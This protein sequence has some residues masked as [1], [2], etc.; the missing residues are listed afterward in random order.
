MGDFSIR[1]PEWNLF[2]CT[3]ENEIKALF[4]LSA[5]QVFGKIRVL[6]SGNNIDVSYVYSGFTTV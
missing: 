2:T 4:Q 5:G 6:V 3:W 1:L